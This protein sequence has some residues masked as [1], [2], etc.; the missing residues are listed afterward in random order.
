M[1]NYFCLAVNKGLRTPW[2]NRGSFCTH[3]ENASSVV[4]EQINATNTL[5][6][7]REIRA[8][9]RRHLLQTPWV[10]S[11]VTVRLGGVPNTAVRLR[12]ALTALSPQLRL[13]WGAKS[14]SLVSKCGSEAGGGGAQ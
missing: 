13:A 1:L 2:R 8:G 9:S 6:L 12:G 4:I 7:F 3:F 14:Q 5:F 10:G 11:H